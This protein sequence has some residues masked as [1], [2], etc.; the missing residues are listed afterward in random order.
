MK[1]LESVSENSNVFVHSILK[2]VCAVT[3]DH[4]FLNSRVVGE[5]LLELA[6]ARHVL[7]VPTLVTGKELTTIK[8]LHAWHRY[9]CYYPFIRYCVVVV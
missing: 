3:D 5:D 9:L 6:H 4:L 2:A 1:L 7:V 8:I